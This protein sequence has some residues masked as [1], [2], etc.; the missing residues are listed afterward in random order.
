VRVRVL[1]D[2]VGSAQILYQD[3][4]A[5]RDAGCTLPTHSLWRV[6]KLN[7]RTHGAFW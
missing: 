6:D 7:R 4:Q 3:E 1:L 5:F 2:G